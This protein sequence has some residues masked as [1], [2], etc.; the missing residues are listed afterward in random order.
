MT[1]LV[2]LSSI[3]TACLKFLSP[4]LKFREGLGLDVLVI[5]AYIPVIAMT[6]DKVGLLCRFSGSGHEINT[7]SWKKTSSNIM[8]CVHV[9]CKHLWYES[10]V[11]GY[12]LSL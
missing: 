11:K 4:N 3:L 8:V 1:S 6:C 2:L 10:S 5:G 7:I 9:I 12:D